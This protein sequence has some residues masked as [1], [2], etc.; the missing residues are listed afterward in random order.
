MK[1]MAAFWMGW[2]MAFVILSEYAIV[3]LGAAIS[4]AFAFFAWLRADQRAPVK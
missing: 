3:Q 4:A 1:T 2:S